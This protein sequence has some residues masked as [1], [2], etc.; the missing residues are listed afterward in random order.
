MFGAAPLGPSLRLFQSGCL[1]NIN[2]DAGTLETQQHSKC[3]D[4]DSN[5]NRD[6]CYTYKFDTNGAC[7]GSNNNEENVQKQ[8]SA[9]LYLQYTNK[10]QTGS[11][12]IK[13]NEVEK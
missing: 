3:Y 9:N 4:L 7:G 2:D 10:C 5:G 12:E 13:M 11:V 8:D 6:V 1:A